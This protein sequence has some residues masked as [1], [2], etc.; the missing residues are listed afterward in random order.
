[1]RLKLFASFHRILKHGGNYNFADRELQSKFSESLCIFFFLKQQFCFMRLF[2]AVTLIFSAVMNPT[3]L[4][5]R[6]WSGVASADWVFLRVQIILDVILLHWW[7]VGVIEYFS[8]F[9]RERHGCSLD[10]YWRCSSAVSC[11]CTFMQ[12]PQT[13][14]FSENP[15]KIHPISFSG[16]KIVTKMQL[17][18]N[19]G[20]YIILYTESTSQWRVKCNSEL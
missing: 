20:H 14:L 6:R 16:I 12:S 10:I 2:A 11:S 8:R 17:G 9:T 5:G 7:S 1:M 19:D 18:R 4:E 3:L 15:S 13:R